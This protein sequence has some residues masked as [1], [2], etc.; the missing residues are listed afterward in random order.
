MDMRLDLPIIKKADAKPLAE[1]PV[2]LGG[3][4]QLVVVRDPDGN[5][6]ELIGPTKE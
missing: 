5:F 4:T 6:I 1:T 3:K 2:S